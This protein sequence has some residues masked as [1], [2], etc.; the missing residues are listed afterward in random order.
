MNKFVDWNDAE[1]ESIKERIRII[2]EGKVKF[3]QSA[4]GSDPRDVIITGEALA[5][6]R[7]KLAELEEMLVGLHREG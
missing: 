5:E 2:E 3:H 7:R 1:I 4:P 6:N